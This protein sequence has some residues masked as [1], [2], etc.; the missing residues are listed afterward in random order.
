VTRAGGVL[1]VGLPGPVLDRPEAA[2]LT[3]LRPAGVIFF[4]R[5]FVDVEQSFELVAAVRAATPESLFFVDAEGGRV[6]RLRKLVGPAPAAATLATLPP[7]SARRA[8]R[9]VGQAMRGFDLDVDLAPV[10]DLD[11]AA[12]DNALDGRYFGATPRAVVARA[13][14][15]IAG[16]HDAGVGSCLKHF[17]GLGAARTDTHHALAVVELGPAAQRRELLPFEQLMGE[18]GAVLLSHAIYPQLDRSGLPATLSPAIASRLLR[19]RLR[20]RGLAISDDLEMGAL[21]SWGDLGARAALALAAGCDLLPI[22]SRLDA[23]AEVVGRL[24]RPRLRERISE[25]TA[26]VAR[27]RRRLR[28]LR[29]G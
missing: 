12:V 22:C 13:R 20:F 11:H 25:A 8:G 3:R 15:F 27:Y 5:N 4:G 6:D 21:A 7:E 19:R 14:A 18:S 9:W 23:V 1:V 10:V 28:E 24:S 16:L 29:R 2:F 26:R 17:P